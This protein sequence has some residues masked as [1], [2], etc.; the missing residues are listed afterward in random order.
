VRRP[1]AGLTAVGSLTSAA[2]NYDLLFTILEGE[3]WQ[4][5]VATWSGQ[6]RKAMLRWL[7]PVART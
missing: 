7:V 2:A 4:G 5:D 6:C 3:C 1:R